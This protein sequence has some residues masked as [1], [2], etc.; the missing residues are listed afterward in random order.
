MTR[1]S[2][3][4]ACRTTR[5]KRIQWR[6]MLKPFDQ[7]AHDNRSRPYCSTITPCQN[8]QQVAVHGLYKLRRA[9]NKLRN[10]SNDRQSNRRVSFR[11]RGFQSTV[12]SKRRCRTGW[13]LSALAVRALIR[14][15]VD[16]DGDAR[17]DVRPA[18]YEERQGLSTV[19]AR[20][21]V[22]SRR[23]R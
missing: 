8:K 6:P 12:C 11:R 7:M 10:S 3:E 23:W 4:L 2:R 14:R 22:N 16:Q 9:T 5:H 15:T 1:A 17:C 21:G 13:P 18:V 20:A 19:F